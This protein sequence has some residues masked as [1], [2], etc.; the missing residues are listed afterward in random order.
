MLGA[1]G[2]CWQ[3]A[4]EREPIF[5]RIIRDDSPYRLRAS[6]LALACVVS[7]SKSEQCKLDASTSSLPRPEAPPVPSDCSA[8]LSQRNPNDRQ[9]VAT[10]GD[11]ANLARRAQ[12]VA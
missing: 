10:S 8:S 7:R 6:A 9:Y 4:G 5:S 1:Y 12:A 2:L 11:L 3:F